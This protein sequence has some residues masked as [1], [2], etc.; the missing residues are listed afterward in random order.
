M[1]DPFWSKFTD[2]AAWRS[3]TSRIGSTEP[4]PLTIQRDKKTE[5]S[6]IKQLLASQRHVDSSRRPLLVVEQLSF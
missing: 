1:K 3:G 5:C 6:G 2:F 4:N